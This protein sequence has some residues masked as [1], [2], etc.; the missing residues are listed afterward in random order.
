MLPNSVSYC[1]AEPSKVSA[2]APRPRKRGRFRVHVAG[3]FNSVFGAGCAA[4]LTSWPPAFNLLFFLVFF[5]GDSSL[6]DLF[7]IYIYPRSSGQFLEN[8]H[9]DNQN[10]VE[11]YDPVGNAW[12]QLANLPEPMGHIGPGTFSS[13]EGIFVLG[14]YSNT[15][16]S[17]RLGHSLFVRTLPRFRP[18]PASPN[19]RVR[20]PWGRCKLGKVMVWHH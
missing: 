4:T 6:F 7:K 20:D 13:A 9:H 17:G 5:A 16:G 2:A 11:V 10:R 1:R 14:G 3:Y 15:G 18:N 8:E 19:S 12:T